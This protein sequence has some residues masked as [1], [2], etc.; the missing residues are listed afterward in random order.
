MESKIF[1]Q[2]L[3]KAGTA[4]LAYFQ[5]KL[6]DKVKAAFLKGL[7]AFR[8]VL[9]EE[10]KGDLI[11]CAKETVAEAEVFLTSEEAEVKEKLILDAV[12][13]KIQL[14]VIL[15]PFKGIVRKVIKSKLEDLIKDLLAKAKDILK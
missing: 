8:D 1:V 6:F 13:M 9:W 4:I 11:S 5:A 15:R 14:P 2:I 10:L 12:M 3:K 7:A